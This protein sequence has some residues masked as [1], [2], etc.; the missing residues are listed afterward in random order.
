MGD[1]ILFVVFQ[2]AA[3]RGVPEGNPVPERGEAGYREP[4]AIKMYLDFAEHG[5]IV[6][7]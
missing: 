6:P 3:A 7:Y 1:H 5:I 2:V 4:G